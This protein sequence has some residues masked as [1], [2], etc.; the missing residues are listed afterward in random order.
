MLLCMGSRLAT[1]CWELCCTKLCLQAA[2]CLELLSAFAPTK[3]ARRASRACYRA[4]FSASAPTQ[5]ARCAARGAAPAAA[6]CH[7]SPPPGSC[8][9]ANGAGRGNSRSSGLRRCVQASLG[10]MQPVQDVLQVLLQRAVQ[11]PHQLSA[12]A[13][14]LRLRCRPHLTAHL[15]KTV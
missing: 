15:S 4:Q 7:A 11:Q 9:A 8:R 13:S 1:A 12:T 5:A 2:K 3:V 10:V 14:V 6:G